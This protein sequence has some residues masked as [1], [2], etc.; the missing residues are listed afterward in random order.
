MYETNA[1]KRTPLLCTILVAEGAI[2]QPQAKRA[3]EEWTRRREHNRSLSFGQ[4]VVSLQLVRGAAMARYVEMQRK[5]AGAPGNTPL[6][7]LLIENN[8][9][10]PSQVLDA[11]KRREESGK[12]LG[13]LLIAEGLVRR[14][15]VDMLLQAQK[16][17]QVKLAA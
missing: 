1:P 9:L 13:E 8:V 2:T 3:L 17:M 5:L 11:L 4:V 6:G 16:R 12:R 7:V 15:Q 10:K 14:I